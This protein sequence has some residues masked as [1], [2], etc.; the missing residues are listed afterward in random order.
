MLLL[1]SILFSQT[2]KN[3]KCDSLK[4]AYEAKYEEFEKMR[5]LMKKD[6]ITREEYFSYFNNY[7]P[8]W[9]EYSKT[10]QKY[11]ECIGDSAEA[12]NCINQLPP[13]P[14]NT[15]AYPMTEEEK[16]AEEEEYR[17]MQPLTIKPE[18]IP[19]SRK[20]MYEYINSLYKVRTD[21]VSG[22]VVLRFICSEE[23]IP[24]E[25]KVF[26]EDPKDMG[27]GAEAIKAVKF[28]RFK[29]G[30]TVDRPVAVRM[31]LPIVFE[32]KKKDE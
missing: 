30:M 9:V 5:V 32:P 25:I 13:P 23:G 1:T 10:K 18:M 4:A 15:P 11:F 26:S 22:K 29:P 3:N 14:P 12:E 8:L 17:R 21:Q 16:K 2:V 20:K 27:L 31:Q 6:S 7:T 28:V 19:E 24:V